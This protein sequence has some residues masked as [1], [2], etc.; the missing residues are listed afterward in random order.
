MFLKKEHLFGVCEGK[1]KNSPEN[2]LGGH[3]LTTG[4]QP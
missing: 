1:L 4:I 3:F 2:N